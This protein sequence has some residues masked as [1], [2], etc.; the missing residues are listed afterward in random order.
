MS[1]GTAHRTKSVVGHTCQEDFHP[2]GG[3]IYWHD[4]SGDQLMI[5]SKKEDVH[6][7]LLA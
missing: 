3:G 4:Q 5:N 1:T 7:P 2:R 6:F